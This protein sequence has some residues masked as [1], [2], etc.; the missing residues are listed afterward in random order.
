MKSSQA[1]VGTIIKYNNKEFTIIA[2]DENCA[3]IKNGSTEI[4]TRLGLDPRYQGI[5]RL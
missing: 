1:K 3:T 4:V 2:M 5:V